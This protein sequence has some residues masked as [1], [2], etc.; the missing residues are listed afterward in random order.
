MLI[1]QT[2]FKLQYITHSNEKFSHIDGAK[3]ALDG[4]CRW[5]QLRIKKYHNETEL[6]TVAN[7][8]KDLCKKYDAIFLIDDYVELV[9]KIDADGVHLGKN[10]MLPSKAREI[11]GENKIIGGTANTSEDIQFLALQKVSY[12]GLGPFRFTTTKEKLSQILGI[13][14]YTQIFNEIKKNISTKNIPIV[15]IGGIT[16]DD[17]TAILKTGANGVAISGAIL[18]AVNPTNETKA[19]IDEI[20]K[21]DKMN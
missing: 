2:K 20:N 6:L 4:G 12:I 16:K 11:L 3:F 19:I 18:N 21:F 5:I 17:V 14:G 7:E 10:D 15:T 13:E 8:L 9:K 1:N